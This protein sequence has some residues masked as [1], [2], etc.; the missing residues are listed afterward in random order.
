MSG[1]SELL[2][3][4]ALTATGAL[5]SRLNKEDGT[6]V[7]SPYALTPTAW[8]HDAAAEMLRSCTTLIVFTSFFLTVDDRM[9]KIYL[10]ASTGISEP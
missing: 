8:H 5:R 1:N 10:S 3:T 6:I 9:N 4:A 7:F 2:V